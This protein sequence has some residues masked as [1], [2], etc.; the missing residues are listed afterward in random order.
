MLRRDPSKLESRL[1]VGLFV[2]YPRG[3]GSGATKRLCGLERTRD[4]ATMGN[5]NFY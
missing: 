2:G 3:V 4:G 1:E 5:F